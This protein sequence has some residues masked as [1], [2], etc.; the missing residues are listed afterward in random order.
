M[1]K[2]IPLTIT[3]LLSGKNVAR[4]T[5]RTVAINSI[6]YLFLKISLLAV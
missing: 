4:K 6:I 5:C 2:V 1:V 3:L